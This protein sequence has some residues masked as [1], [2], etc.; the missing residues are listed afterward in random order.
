MALEI[1]TV[2]FFDDTRGFGFAKSDRYSGLVYVHRTRK[3]SA[4]VNEHGDFDIAKGSRLHG[5]VLSVVRPGGKPALINFM[6]AE[7]SSDTV[8][9]NVQESERHREREEKLTNSAYAELLLPLESRKRKFDRST[10]PVV[11]NP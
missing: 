1:F 7:R 3:N 4:W 6:P 10:P 5:T 2:T 11:V 9:A 8:E